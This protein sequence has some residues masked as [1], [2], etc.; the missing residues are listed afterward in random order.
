MGE[1]KRRRMAALARA[2]A[3]QRHRAI[4]P[5]TKATPPRPPPPRPPLPPAPPQ[6]PMAVSTSEPETLTMPETTILTPV[7]IPVA[8]PVIR[9]PQPVSQKRTKWWHL[10]LA[11]GFVGVP[12]TWGVVQT[13]LNAMKLFE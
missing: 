5:V 8:P 3:N 12:L 2:E 1:A 13:I 10:F 6:R 4:G 7:T 11:W 9:V